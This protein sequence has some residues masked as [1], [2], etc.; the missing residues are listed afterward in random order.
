MRMPRLVITT[1]LLVLVAFAGISTYA[2][3]LVVGMIADY[4]GSGRFVAA[5]LLGALFVRLPLVRDGK[6]RTIGILPK[7]VRLPA[8]LVLLAVCLIQH[9]FQRDALPVLA[10]GLAATVPLTFRWIR[11]K[12]INRMSV[13][14]KPTRAPAAPKSVDPSVID[15]DFREKKD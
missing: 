6:L 5:L 10:L 1:L 4:V 14:F 11:Q 7:K 3:Y 8:M 13:F 15:V 9:A 2:G 12:L